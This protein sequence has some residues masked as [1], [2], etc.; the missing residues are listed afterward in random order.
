MIFH[1]KETENI[2]FVARP[3]GSQWV[4][5]GVSFGLCGLRRGGGVINNAHGVGRGWLFLKFEG[6]C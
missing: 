4:V 2:E 5:K 6:L 3:S 1:K